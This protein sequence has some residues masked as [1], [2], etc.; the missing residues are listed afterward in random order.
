MKKMKK[1]KIFTLITLSVLLFAQ[2]DDNFDELNT[3][4]NAAISVDP[5]TLL[6]SAQYNFYNALQGPT[7]N[8]DW[9]L[10]MVQQWAQTEYTE[11]S[12]Y[13]QDITFFD[14]TWSAMYAN[15]LKEL[16]AAKS[17]VESQEV[18]AI[19]KANRTAILDVMSTQAYCFLTDAFGSVPYTEAVDGIT[20]LPKYD[21]QEV[22]YKGILETLQNASASF[23]TAGTSFT[24]G[25][26]IYGGDISSWIKFTNSLMLRYAMRLADADAATAKQ[27]IDLAVTN[28]ISSNSE[29]ALFAFPESLA[30][31]NPLFRNV[32]PLS[33]NRDDYAVSEY[34]VTTLTDL[35]DPRL[36]AFA[37][38]YNGEYV[39][40][41]YGISDNDATVLKPVTSR[42]ND[43][44][45]SATTPHVIISF[46]E[47]QFLLAEAYQRGIISGDATAAYATAI[48]AS[49][50]YWGIL[51]DTAIDA[52][53]ASNSYDATNWKMS[54]GNQK[55]IALYMNGFE[56]WNEWRRLDYPLL[57][58]PAAAQLSSIPVRMPYPLS[59]TQS[60]SKELGLV[61][62]TP[63]DMTTKVWW[64]KN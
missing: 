9:G 55:W 2:C 63:A 52:Y 25:E 34:L 16:E 51:D 3:D 11:D 26:I 62:S 29:N 44:V 40:M 43:N 49:M 61:T 28:L 4:P 13:N 59:E 22:I 42:P 7:I 54:I 5:S 64:D 15:V 31:A 41:P 33:G 18:S 24:S 47:V 39:G 6:T 45:R 30:R 56:G 14:N 36:G 20:N 35:E 50:N 37:N 1:M 12:R 53:V 48:K 8:A 60:N 46:A 38:T 58:V 17:L 32:S 21:D 27:Y 23:N 10:L 19:T 57:T